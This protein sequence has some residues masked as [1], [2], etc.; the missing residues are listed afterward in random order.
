[1]VSD[2][3]MDL[4]NSTGELEFAVKRC[5]QCGEMVDPVIQRNRQLRHESMAV[6]F[7]EKAFSN[8]CVTVGPK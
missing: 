1:M 3:C 6:P 7:V 8:S 2:F 5:V 4:Q